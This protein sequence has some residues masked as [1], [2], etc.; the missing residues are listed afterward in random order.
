LLQM[1]Y[2]FPV[3]SWA[4]PSAINGTAQVWDL[5]NWICWNDTG[6]E[7]WGQDAKN[8][9]TMEQKISQQ[10]KNS[11]PL[12]TESAQSAN[13]PSPSWPENDYNQRIDRIHEFIRNGDVYQVNL[14]MPFLC[15]SPWQAG[16]DTEIFLRLRESSPAPYAALFRHA[17]KSLISHSPE[18]F[19]SVHDRQCSSHPIK[20]TCKRIDGHEQ[21]QRAALRASKK[22]QA[23]LAM[24][25]DL[26][27]NDIGRI[28]EAGSV[29]VDGTEIMDLP[30]VHHALAHIRSR[31][32]NNINHQE[33]LA[34]CFPAGSI[35][36]APKI[37]AMEI[38]QVLETQARQGY[39]G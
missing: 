16:N 10:C 3:G 35:T 20:G 17:E 32:K 12:S 1:D 15:N 22:D 25:V 38:I 19:L 11:T 8:T 30:Y 36:G 5:N 24:I 6:C 21:Q 37:R 14:T 13:A 26:V 9:A 2:E 29:S 31:L 33:L 23:E 27:R 7:I 34:A 28:S 4:A 39:C 18:R